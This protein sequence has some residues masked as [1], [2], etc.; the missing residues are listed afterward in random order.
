MAVKMERRAVELKTALAQRDWEA[1]AALHWSAGA[2]VTAKRTQSLL[3]SRLDDVGAIDDIE[4][5]YIE[6]DGAN[7]LE[8]LDAEEIPAAYRD[9]LRGHADIDLGSLFQPDGSYLEDTSAFEYSV[10]VGEVDGR[11]VVLDFSAAD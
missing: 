5:W 7:Y 9:T 2:P 4:A 8:Y 6:Y 1:V 11:F 3:E 10:F